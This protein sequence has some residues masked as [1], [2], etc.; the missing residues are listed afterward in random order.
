MIK[1]NVNLGK[2]LGIPLRLHYTWFIIF[3]LVTYSLIL[4]ASEPVYP[5]RE[6][7]VF[8]LLAS[9]LFFACIVAHELAHSVVAVRNNIPVSEI[10]LF[11]FG[12]VSHVTREVTRPRVELMIAMVGPLTSLMLSG[13]FYGL[14]LLLVESGLTLA[15]SLMRWLAIINLILA[16]FNL[17]PGFPLDGGRVFRALIWQRTEDYLK[18]TRVAT[19]VGQ[20]IAYGFIVAGLVII[21]SVHFWLNGLW[22][23]FIGWF[24]Q[25]AAR[26]S[27]YQVLLR[28]SL[29]GLT[30]GQV[31]DYGCPSVSPHLNLLDLVQQY[32]LPRGRDCFLVSEGASVL[33]MLT[34]E[35]IRKVPRDRWAIT[36]VMDVMLS[37]DKLKAVPADQE[38]SS[39][40]AEVTGR[41]TEHLAVM[42][43]GKIVGVIA[44]DNLLR[45]L[46]IRTD[47]G[48][49]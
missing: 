4:Y 19:K 32:V 33:G 49:K 22:L 30:A 26:A 45:L 31:A 46:R 36:T 9:V 28:S 29:V 39:V 13:I 6:R 1:G 10:T 21:F 5:L 41:G 17:I 20:G 43:G 7:L 38:L 25:D 40:L 23:I 44:R 8:G 12:G 34:L 11:V 14:H 3:V 35:Q 48:T 27:Y 37:A 18:A 42:E 24:L 2:V 47:F 15:A 16:L